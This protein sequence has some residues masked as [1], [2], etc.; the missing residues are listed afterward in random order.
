MP[1]LPR[2]S[3][4]AKLYTIFALLATATMALAFLAAIGLEL[5]RGKIVEQWQVQELALPI[6]AELQFPPSS[7]NE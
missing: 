1:K 7:S 2:L 3:I 6:L 5:R 4:A